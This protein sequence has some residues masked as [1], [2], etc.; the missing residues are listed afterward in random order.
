MLLE[1]GAYLNT[2]NNKL[3]TIGVKTK[4]IKTISFLIE[5]KFDVN[6]ND[7]N[8]LLCAC[9]DENPSFDV[10]KLLIDNGADVNHK[11]SLAFKYACYFGNFYL[12][13]YFVKSGADIHQGLKYV[14]Y[15]KRSYIYLYLSMLIVD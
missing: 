7:G 3:L 10:V 12:V 15:S 11:N 9:R 6:S 4:N 14:K 5:K 1:N 2:A 13:E 8:A